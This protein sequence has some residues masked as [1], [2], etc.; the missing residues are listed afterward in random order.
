MAG[1]R[2]FDGSLLALALLAALAPACE[3]TIDR[4]EE[5]RPPVLSLVVTEPGAVDLEVAGPYGL[6]ALQARL[7]YDPQQVQLTKVEPGV[8]AA[9][10]DRVFFADPSKANGSLVFGLTDT[11]AV[12]LPARGALLRFHLQPAG[13]ASAATLSVTEP[14]GAIDGGERVDL[15][16]TSLEVKLP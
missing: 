5:L 8:D 2:T 7:V 16:P 4:T 15:A 1:K 11:R 3:Q 9:R 13:G 6:R 12:M 10:L 14:L